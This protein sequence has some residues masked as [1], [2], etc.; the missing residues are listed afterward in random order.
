[1]WRWIRHW[2]DWAM[3]EIVTPRRLAAQPQGLYYRFEKGGLTLDQQP[4]PWSAEAV[5]FCSPSSALETGNRATAPLIA[6]SD[7]PTCW[8]LWRNHSLTGSTLRAVQ[9]LR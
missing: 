2:R 3:T 9:R 4:V 5:S 6:R 8:N 1:M 7:R